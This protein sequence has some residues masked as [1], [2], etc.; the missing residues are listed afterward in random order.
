MLLF[1]AQYPAGTRQGQGQ[2]AHQHPV[3][4]GEGAG[5][6]CGDGCRHPQGQSVTLFAG[7]RKLTLKPADLDYYRGERGRR[8]AKLPAVLQRVDR[9]E[10]EAVAGGE[11]VAGKIR[12]GDKQ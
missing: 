7:K 2:Q 3:G 4:S 5:G 11:P 10:I 6:V 1:P 9:I 12:K 8:G